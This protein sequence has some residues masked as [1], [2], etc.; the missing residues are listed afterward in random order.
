MCG[1]VLGWFITFFFAVLLQTVPISGNWELSGN[2]LTQGTTIDKYSMY[3]CGA[4]FEIA[5]DVVTLILPLFVIWRLQMQTTQ[6]WQ[7]SGVFL[8]GSL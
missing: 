3:I 1:L 5:L 4:V 7:V 2:G 8:L 6:K